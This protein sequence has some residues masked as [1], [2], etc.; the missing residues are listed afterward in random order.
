MNNYSFA[1][2]AIIGLIILAAQFFAQNDSNLFGSSTGLESIC[3][4]KH[5]ATVTILTIV[6]A[7]GAACLSICDPSKSFEIIAALNCILLPT[8]TVIQLIEWYLR[9]RVFFPRQDMSTVPDIEELP[10]IC[11]PAALAWLAGITVGVATSG[12]IPQLELLHMGI[13]P[14]QSWLTTAVVY[15]IL[16]NYQYASER[17]E[18]S[19]L[20]GAALPRSAAV[21][22]N[23]SQSDRNS[24]DNI[25][26]TVAKR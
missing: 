15:G 11:W 8:P 4:I 24:S 12:L 26:A 22:S 7:I 13:C 17:F 18:H 2:F 23:K 14:I 20:T 16:R 21:S 10:A 19:I 3:P 9:E 6:C 25:K 5:K 1:G